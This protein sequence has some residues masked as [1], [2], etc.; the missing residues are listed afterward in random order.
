[1][2]Q[3]ISIAGIKPVNLSFNIIQVKLLRQ[4]LSELPYEKVAPVIEVFDKQVLPQLE[5]IKSELKTKFEQ[6]EKVDEAEAVT[7][8]EN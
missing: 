3:E 7:D 1:M 2:N 6:E 4:L 8:S 5:V